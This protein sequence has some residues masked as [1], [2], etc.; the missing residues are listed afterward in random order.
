VLD[1]SRPELSAWCHVAIRSELVGKQ[2]FDLLV[3]DVAVKQTY[4]LLLCVASV[5]VRYE[6]TREL[7]ANSACKNL[8]CSFVAM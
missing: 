7:S 5:G 8:E 3:S 2:A 6:K 1:E 4:K